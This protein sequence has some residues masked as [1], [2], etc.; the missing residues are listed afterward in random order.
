M[1]MTQTYHL[2]AEQPE[3]RIEQQ[4]PFKRLRLIKAQSNRP[5]SSHPLAGL[6]LNLQNKQ[7]SYNLYTFTSPSDSRFFS[8]TNLLEQAARLPHLMKDGILRL[9]IHPELF[10]LDQQTE[11]VIE[12]EIQ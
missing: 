5:V 8:S 10:V 6:R 12:L 9:I 3:I 7:Y 11:V 4:S 1:S 2:N